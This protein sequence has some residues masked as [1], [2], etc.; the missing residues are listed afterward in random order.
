MHLLGVHFPMFLY[1]YGMN[2]Q[3]HPAAQSW[4]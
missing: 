2:A 1:S 4:K 3:S